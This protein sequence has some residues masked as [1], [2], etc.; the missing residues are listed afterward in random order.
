MAQG[1]KNGK[2]IGLILTILAIVVGVLLIGSL[3]TCLCTCGTCVGFNGCMPVCSEFEWLPDHSD[4]WM[5]TIPPQTAAPTAAPTKAP[6]EPPSE[7]TAPASLS[8]FDDEHQ[9]AGTPIPQD[10]SA[11]VREKQ[12]QLRNDGT[13][14]V[15]VLVLMNGSDL[16]SEY[17]EATEDL[18]EMVRAKKSDRMNI[19]VETVG[20]KKWD[21]RFG[22]SSRHAQ[23]WRVTAGGLDL[24]D[25]SLP[26]LDTT[27]P[28]TLSDFIRWG[29]EYAPADRYIL[30]LWDHGGGPVYGYGYDEFQPYTATLTIDEMQTALRDGGVYFDLIG[31]DC[32]LMSSLEVCCALYDY[33]DYTLLSEDFE[34]GCGWAHE[35]WLSALADDPAIG[36]PALGQIAIDDSIRIAE[37]R[38]SE[39]DGMTLALIDEAYMT[40]L[41]PAWLEFAYSSE[42]ALLSANYSQLR[43]STGRAHPRLARAVGGWFTDGDDATLEDYC[44][45]DMLS[46]AA[47]IASPASGSL[48]AAL[49]QAI[50]YYGATANETTL[51]GLSVTLPYG[52]D[53]FYRELR[54]VFLNAGFDE[55]YVD[56][57]RQFVSVRT[58]T[59]YYD[60]DGWNGWDDYAGDYDWS[61]WD[62]L[63]GGLS[64][65]AE[66]WTGDWDAGF[67]DMLDWLFGA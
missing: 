12:V 4:A 6:T 10:P 11:W 41:Y 37:Q 66:G 28:S 36:T 15:T 9:P 61:D 63:F 7:S 16:E 56:W 3:C 29:V 8:P 48:S 5:E 54:R 21:S 53:A 19:L 39:E 31:M 23:R 24:L 44:I 27:I 43:E 42:E 64:D 14:T 18:L 17:G 35:G 22:I 25:D 34:P 62:G 40:L 67:D 32:C 59:E 55:T 52:D 2:L 60:F 46:L 65:W 38:S 26:Q 20:T 1:N 51:S 33:C 47:N 30:L 49:D 57:L 50:V 45:T 13:D 58:D